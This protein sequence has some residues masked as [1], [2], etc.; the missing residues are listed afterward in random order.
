VLRLAAEVAHTALGIA[1]VLQTGIDGRID[2]AGK[3]R[4]L[5]LLRLD[6]GCGHQ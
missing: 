2:R 4:G 5:A 3:R 6:C 1:G